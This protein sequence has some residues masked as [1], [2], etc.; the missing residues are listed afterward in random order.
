MG[1]TGSLGGAQACAGSDSSEWSM[2]VNGPL[3]A[4]ALPLTESL[5]RVKGDHRGEAQVFQLWLLRLSKI[6]IFCLS[7]PLQIAGAYSN[8][9]IIR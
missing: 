8:L 6:I 4:K 9:K 2:E 7:L 5:H 3:K 1:L